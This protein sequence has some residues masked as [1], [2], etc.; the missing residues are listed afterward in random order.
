MT[1][2]D[3]FTRFT[4]TQI[5]LGL[6]AGR[7]I[8]W[9]VDSLLFMVFPTTFQN[10]MALGALVMIYTVGSALIMALT[11]AV[12]SKTAMSLRVTVMLIGVFLLTYSLDTLLLSEG[13]LSPQ[14]SLFGVLA[15][16]LF[17]SLVLLRRSR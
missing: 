2:T 5:V 12:L 6:I 17:L 16:Q 8:A 9:F 1:E 15:F 3:T 11:L 13:L 10:P 4:V 7:I 14:V